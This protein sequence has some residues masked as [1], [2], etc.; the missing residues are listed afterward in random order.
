MHPFFK[1]SQALFEDD[2]RIHPESFAFLS[3]RLLHVYQ[4]GVTQ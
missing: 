1:L 2:V 3:F 4:T